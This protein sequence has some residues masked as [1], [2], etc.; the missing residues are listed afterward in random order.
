MSEIICI[1]WKKKSS[2]KVIHYDRY[3]QANYACW[4]INQI[5]NTYVISSILL[6]NSDSAFEN[7]ILVSVMRN[8]TLCNT[9]IVSLSEHLQSNI[10]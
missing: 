1:K 7:C 5:S 8:H 10:V 3:D 4:D 6:L 2:K 9:E